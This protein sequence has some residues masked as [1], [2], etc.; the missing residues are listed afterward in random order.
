[1]TVGRAEPKILGSDTSDTISDRPGRAETRAIE[2]DE[3]RDG[4]VRSN[5]IYRCATGIRVGRAD[6]KGGDLRR[7]VDVTIDHNLLEGGGSS[8][9][10]AFA[11]EAGERIRFVNNVVEGYA[12]AILVFGKPPQTKEVTVANNL[13]LGASDLAFLLEA[14]DSARLFDYNI[15][16]ARRA[17]EVQVGG[18]KVPLARY[19]EGGA[20]PNSRA[21]PGV[22]ILQRDLARIV[23]IP[24]IDRGSPLDGI[25]Y[26]GAAPD[27]GV[28]E[29]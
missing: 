27:I 9:A 21:V 3:V 29:R 25:P 14:P 20:M 5:R 18:R 19:L 2:L 24:V 28:A 22:R 7:A 4:V 23:G 12:D 8:R 11:V 1:M 10:D 6:P 16:S 17:A 26:S 15:F 13:V